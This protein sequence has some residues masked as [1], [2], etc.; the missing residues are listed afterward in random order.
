[1]AISTHARTDWKL[2]KLYW[3]NPSVDFSSLKN[4]LDL[5]TQ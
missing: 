4:N 3:A 1:M 2:L 5:P